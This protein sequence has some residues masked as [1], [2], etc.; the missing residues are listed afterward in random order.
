MVTRPDPALLN[1][2]ILVS[3]CSFIAAPFVFIP[4]YIRYSTMRYTLDDEG[5]SMSYGFFFRREVYLAYRRIQDIHVTRNIVERWLGLAKVPIQTASGT[6]GPTMQIEGIRDP[7]PLRDYLYQQMRGARG[8]D[9]SGPTT[10]TTEP[11]AAGT[12]DDPAALLRDIRDEVRRLRE[13]LEQ[14]A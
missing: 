6:S 12:P 14:Q 5:I 9:E 10:D 11:D 2:Y 8:L 1:Y 4:L 3:L 13:K 7:E